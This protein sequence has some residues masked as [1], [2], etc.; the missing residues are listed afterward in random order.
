MLA[1]NLE[2]PVFFHPPDLTNGGVASMLTCVEGGVCRPAFL[3]QR[4]FCGALMRVS[5]GGSRG[6]HLIL[7]GKLTSIAIQEK[8]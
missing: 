7:S 1:S 5:K 3:C 6:G 2:S 4:R 8:L